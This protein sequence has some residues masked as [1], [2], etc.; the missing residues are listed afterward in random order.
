MCMCM[1]LGMYTYVHVVYVHVYVSGYVLLCACIH[2][3]EECE[4]QIQPLP[5]PSEMRFTEGMT[6]AKARGI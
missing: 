4:A 6:N 5:G 2:R 3:S 1:C